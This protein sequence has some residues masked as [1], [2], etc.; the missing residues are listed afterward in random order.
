MPKIVD[1]SARRRAVAEAVLRI[2]SRSG[3]EAASLRNVADEAGLAVGSVRHYFTDH[4]EMVIFAMGELADRVERRVRARAEG[5]FAA[6]PGEHRARTEEL[7]TE[8]LPVDDARYEESTL[9]IAFITAARTRPGLRP[10]AV[11]A[12]ANMLVLLR[13]VLCGAQEAGGLP[14]GLDVE[15]ESVRLAALLD[16]LTL[17]AVLEPERVGADVLLGVLRRHLDSLRNG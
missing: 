14:A 3:L 17:Q 13:R 10:R 12:Q 8:L 5:I 1:P 6:G 11:E 7:L 16:G 2:V 4:D 15:L 9:W